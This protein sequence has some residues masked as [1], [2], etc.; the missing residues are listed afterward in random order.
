M[1]FTHTGPVN[2]LQQENSGESLS[3][4]SS[5]SANWQDGKLKMY[6][7]TTGAHEGDT[8]QLYMVVMLP[9][10]STKGIGQCGQDYADMYTDDP[11]PLIR[12]VSQVRPLQQPLLTHILALELP[13][14]PVDSMRC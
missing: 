2:P 1:A 14:H 10:D 6:W 12:H 13:V 3:R 11:D 8:Y 9:D 4:R 7:N 5:L